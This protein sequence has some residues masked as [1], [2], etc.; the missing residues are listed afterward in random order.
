LSSCCITH[1]IPYRRFLF[2]QF[3]IDK[4]KGI[5]S[6]TGVHT[7]VGGGKRN[8]NSKRNDHGRTQRNS[9]SD[10]D[11][12]WDHDNYCDDSSRRYELDT[13]DD[14]KIS[15]KLQ[16]HRGSGN[17]ESEDR[18]RRDGDRD[19]R[20]NDNDSRRRGTSIYH[21]DGDDTDRYRNRRERSD[22]LYHSDEYDD[23]RRDLRRNE[24]SRRDGSRRSSD[25]SD[26]RR[27][28]SNDHTSDD[29]DHEENTNEKFVRKEPKEWPPSF[30]NNGSAF[31]FD[32][33]S[34]MFYEPLSN[35]FYDPKSKLY[36]GNKKFAYYRY[37]DKKEPPFVEVQK[38]TN[39]QVEE[40]QR[41]DS[42][43]IAQEKVAVNNKVS[44]APSKP[45]IAIKFKTKKVKSSVSTLAAR[46]GANQQATTATVS[47][48]K[49]QQIANI[50]KWN[51][52]Q[53]E[54]K[55]SVPNSAPNTSNA[56]SEKGSQVPNPKIRTTAKGEPICLLC[57]RKFPNLAKLRLH[58]KG[59]EL[60]KKNL[61]KLQEKMKQ[62]NAAAGTK[63]KLDEKTTSAVDPSPNHAT[64]TAT[65][66]ATAPVYTD[67]AEKRRQLHGVDLCAPTNAL[68]S[69]RQFETKP[70]TSSESRGG[71]ASNPPGSDLLNETN[72]GH[73]M[74]QKMGYKTKAEEH[75]TEGS[76]NNSKPKTANEHLRK[77]W[78][79][80]EAMAQKSVPRNR[81]QSR[82]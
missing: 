42:G 55:Q 37:D 60:H 76:N 40:Q 19:D 75:P 22:S 9:Y 69:L 44:T 25:R 28:Y 31:T 35:F 78:D 58:K 4:D 56:V 66:S 36:Y 72:V 38:M 52:K 12:K 2:L 14:R 81:Y 59:S 21:D 30:Q 57:K 47:K 77:E 80:I 3:V 61:L 49:Q 18:F 62:Q 68:Q 8:G 64:E 54:L 5:D 32:V 33:R 73:Q 7:G 65:V 16:D 67:R 51:E 24:R 6:N 15:S 23:S 70:D 27:R 74:L 11:R 20:Y 26:H 41:G 13:D 46:E 63:R 82:S 45:K 48:A 34:A 43:G 17:I 71:S 79:R 1:D 50:G 29:D 10:S 53:A 39:E